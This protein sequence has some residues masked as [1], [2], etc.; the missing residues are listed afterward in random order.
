MN[1]LKHN[2]A[3]R[4]LTSTPK[5]ISRD[6]DIKEVDNLSHLRVTTLDVKLMKEL[7]SM[8]YKVG[9]KGMVVWTSKDGYLIELN[10]TKILEQW[11]EYGQLKKIILYSLVLP[12][13]VKITNFKRIFFIEESAVINEVDSDYSD[14]VYS[15]NQKHNGVLI[16]ETY[17]TRADYLAHDDAGVNSL[18]LR[19]GMLLACH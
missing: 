3:T 13:I 10:N 9:P 4:Q 1:T 14:S 19:E 11:I 6:N 12:Q 2:I 8:K 7:R 17:D 18:I 16:C 15:N 5:P